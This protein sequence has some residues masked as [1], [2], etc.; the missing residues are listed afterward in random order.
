MA[1]ANS[2]TRGELVSE[3]S[4]SPETGEIY[5]LATGKGRGPLG[6][7]AGVVN[8]SLGYRV[9]GFRNRRHYAHR[10]AWLIVHGAW[11]DGQIDHINGDRTDNR[12]ENL[13][14]VTHAQ[15]QMNRHNPRP[16]KHGFRG[17]DVC[18]KTGRYRARLVVGKVKYNLGV[19]DT[20]EQAHQAYLDA[21]KRL[22]P[23]ANL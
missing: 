8:N 23:M 15:N 22:N 3:L 2:F 18:A 14:C 10:L 7:Q 21:K 20:P 5:W 13:R 1:A 16:N 17:L 11:P 9:I 4:Y 19:H 6:Q 12:I